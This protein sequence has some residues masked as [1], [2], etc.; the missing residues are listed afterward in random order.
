M[1]RPG[2]PNT[3]PQMP[4]KNAAT[5]P[6]RTRGQDS[7]VGRNGR[8]PSGRPDGVQRNCCDPVADRM[9]VPPVWRTR[10]GDESLAEFVAVDPATLRRDRSSRELDLT[11]IPA[12]RPSGFRGSRRLHPRRGRGSGSSGSSSAHACWRRISAVT[13]PPTDGLAT[14]PC[15]VRSGSAAERLRVGPRDRY[16]GGCF[17]AGHGSFGEVRRPGGV[18]VGSDISS[19]QIEHAVQ[20]R[21]R[22]LGFLRRR[23]D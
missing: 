21:R 1:S 11:S 22:N 2:S 12:T 23:R 15:F 16:R 19:E 4:M 14:S 3:V 13:N 7:W 20:G 10:T 9:P 6:V 18:S 8:G 5:A 17:G